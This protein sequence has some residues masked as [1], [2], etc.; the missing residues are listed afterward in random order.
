MIR[1]SE[2]PEADGQV[3]KIASAVEPEFEGRGDEAISSP[4]RRT[5][6]LLALEG[7]LHLLVSFFEQLTALK[8][9]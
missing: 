1:H 8:R 5:S 4:V 2:Y 3:K 7:V 6:H 9:A